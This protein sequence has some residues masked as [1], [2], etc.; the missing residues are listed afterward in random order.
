MNTLGMFLSET[1]VDADEGT[2]PIRA[3][4]CSEATDSPF[5]SIRDEQIH[6]LVQ[7]L[8]LRPEGGLVRNVGFA[9]TEESTQMGPLC[10]D[11][12]T[13]LAAGGKYHVGLIDAS[14]DAIPQPE[15]L[16]LPVP[17]PAKVTSPV[18]S[19]VELVSR[20][21]WWPEAGLHPVTDENLE[22]FR[23]LMSGFDF[24]VVCCAPVCWIT[25]RI[26]QHCDGLV[27]VLTANKTRRLVAAQIVDR[28][29]K[30]GVPLLGTV[31]ADRRFP[32]PQG[33]YRSL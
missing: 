4:V 18:S 6:A 19:R 32:I 14:F 11:V 1:P 2:I 20:Q 22:R 24:S 15:R 5:L 8:F 28:L 29:G 10:L 13:A 9:P 31:L 23:E 3:D 17:P 25:A 7:Q 12:A 33:L 16:A 21:S 27:L 30:V 26:G